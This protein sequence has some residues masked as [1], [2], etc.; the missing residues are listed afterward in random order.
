MW[1]PAFLCVVHLQNI[2]Y[3]PHVL[4][5]F[6]SPTDKLVLRQERQDFNF[7]SIDSRRCSEDVYFS[8]VAP[9]VYSSPGIP[10]HFNQVRYSKQIRIFPQWKCLLNSYFN[11]F[12]DVVSSI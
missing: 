10:K 4:L 11:G 9:I 12:V 6:C 2:L 8:F 1:T 5:C 3:M 7:R